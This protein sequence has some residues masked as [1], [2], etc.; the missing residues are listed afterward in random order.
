MKKSFII[1]LLLLVVVFVAALLIYRFF[2]VSGDNSQTS[3]GLTAV[4]GAGANTGS[5]GDITAQSDDF[6]KLLGRLQSIQLNSDVF[7]TLA[8]KS[9]QSFRQDLPEQLKG[10]RNPFLVFGGD[11]GGVSTATTTLVATSTKKKK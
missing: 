9:L 10:R 4:A 5:L 1:K 6:I 7:N 8:W 2:F 3:T 11:S